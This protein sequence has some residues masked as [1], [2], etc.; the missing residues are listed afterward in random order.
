MG[1]KLETALAGLRCKRQLSR[2]ADLPDDACE[3][4]L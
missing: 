4:D 2:R 3:E 1:G